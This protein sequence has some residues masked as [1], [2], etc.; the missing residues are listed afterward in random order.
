VP[1]GTRD[2][3]FAKGDL[4]RVISHRVCEKHRISP[5]A[6]VAIQSISHENRPRYRLEGY[7]SFLVDESE[8]E[9]VAYIRNAS[10]R[11]S[12]GKCVS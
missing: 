11:E 7:S 3:C 10:T 6:I 9:L 4:V 1:L 5:R 8:I 2:L 12:R